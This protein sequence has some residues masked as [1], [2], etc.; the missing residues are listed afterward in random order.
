VRP[1]FAVSK[2]IEV[3]VFHFI[4]HTGTLAEHL[5]QLMGTGLAESTLS[6]RR[7]ALSW[8]LFTDLLRMFLRPLADARRHPDAF[9]KGLRLLAVD[10][11]QF[12]L[13][14]TPQI[15]DKIQKAASRRFKAAW[16]KLS[17]V[18]LLELGMHNPLAAEIS[19][20][21][22]SE[23]ALAKRLWGKLPERTLLLA[24]RLYGSPAMIS[25]IYDRCN[26]VG[27]HF[28][29][30]TKTHHQVKLVK[31]LPDGSFIVDVP[32]ND[33][34]KPRKVVRWMR[35]REINVR[36][37]NANGKA[38]IV[39]LWTT[40]LDNNQ[41]PAIKL[42]RL[43]IRRWEQE[44]YWRQMKL[45]LRKSELLQSHTI[46]TAAQEVVAIILATALIAQER[47]YAASGTTPVLDISFVKCLALIR[48]LWQLTHLLSKVMPASQIES[49]HALIIK[50]IGRLKKQKKRARSCER[51]V[52]QPVS[53]WPRLL[54]PKYA[55]GSTRTSISRKLPPFTER[56]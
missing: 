19:T 28:L 15:L 25:P 12:S 40:L 42:G 30:R 48:P 49:L 45:E 51:A 27:C 55:S 35:L 7:Q 24:D 16:A 4:C 6:E 43:Y 18:V 33:K 26:D 10:G 52:R 36:A 32:L 53:G 8:T 37:I 31:T 2:L 13:T 20:A 23:H 56:H 3:L 11:T 38:E 39:R 54:Q 21:E 1:G 50:E 22:E 17:V 46:E 9:Y 41:F 47:I 29:I 5:R 34:D 44:L 14:N